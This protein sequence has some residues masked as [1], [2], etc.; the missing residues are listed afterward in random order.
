MAVR[1]NSVRSSKEKKMVCMQTAPLVPTPATRDEISS[2]PPPS[3]SDGTATFHLPIVTES[4]GKTL[5][6]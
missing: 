3:S 2:P 4:N 1:A 6:P 5:S